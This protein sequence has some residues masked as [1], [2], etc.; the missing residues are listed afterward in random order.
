MIDFHQHI[1]DHQKQGN[2][3]LNNEYL[4]NLSKLLYNQANFAENR[5]LS[6]VKSPLAY[7]T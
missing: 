6:P 1:D 4:N 7:S 2:D 5:I 3:L